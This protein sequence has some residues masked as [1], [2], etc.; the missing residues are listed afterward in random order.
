MGLPSPGSG[1]VLL[2]WCS[3][4]QARWGRFT[5]IFLGGLNPAG[6]F[7]YLS[8]FAEWAGIA[9]RILRSRIRVVCES[10]VLPTLALLAN[11]PACGGLGLVPIR[12]GKNAVSLGTLVLSRN[13]WRCSDAV[14]DLEW[15]LIGMTRLPEFANNFRSPPQR[16]T[17]GKRQRLDIP[18]RPV[19][20][21]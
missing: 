8:F 14:F 12:S 11:V 20:D 3:L 5:L 2:H 13:L 10:A 21:D 16:L 1:S 7:C 18:S 9:W 17:P 15:P 6:F 4:L 19:N